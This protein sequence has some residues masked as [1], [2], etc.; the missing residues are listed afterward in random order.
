MFTNNAMHWSAL[1]TWLFT[2]GW[3]LVITM[4]QFSVHV[5]MCYVVHLMHCSHW[6]G[7]WWCSPIMQC[8]EVHCSLDCSHW[9]GGR[10]PQWNLH[11]PLSRLTATQRGE[12]HD[13]HHINIILSSYD[14][15][16][17]IIW[18]SPCP[19][20]MIII[21]S[22]PRPPVQANC[23]PERGTPCLSSWWSSY[24]HIIIWWSSYDQ[25]IIWWSNHHV[26]ILISS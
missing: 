4:A 5:K 19:H 1:F 24:D 16:L 22:S 13:D 26:M 3:W 12:S 17:I 6:G 10:W 11:A 23:H 7:G 15:H 2:L 8:I 9:D 20:M 25:I 21:S 14:D 18:W